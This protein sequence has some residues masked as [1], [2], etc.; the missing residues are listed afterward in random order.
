MCVKALISFIVFFSTIQIQAQT[1]FDFTVFSATSINAQQS[2]YQGLTGALG[3]IRL[4]QFLIDS[5]R[6]RATNRILMAGG[7]FIFFGGQVHPGE[8]LV[9]GT[10]YLS[11]VGIQGSLS[12]GS[13]IRL[14]YSSV[15]GNVKHVGLLELN[16]TEVVGQ[17]QRISQLNVEEHLN[18]VNNEMKQ[19]SAEYA[20]RPGRMPLMNHR[21]I[22]L[23]ANSGWNT[24]EI[25]DST[26]HQAPSLSIYGPPDA[27]IIINVKGERIR[28]ARMGIHLKGS[29]RPEQVLFNFPEAQSLIIQQSGD[30]SLRGWGIPG[31]FLAPYAHTHF[32]DA[33]ITGGLFVH[34]LTGRGPGMPAG[35]VNYSRFLGRNQSCN[36]QP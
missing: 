30:F 26:F 11:Q 1:L 33:L 29:L 15:I 27:I 32:H 4:G 36:C 18:R 6:D 16:R 35:Q 12:S 17:A 24:F 7:D 34:S 9:Q 2:D 14:N 20:S 22:E 28:I 8:I 25:Q 5:P 21:N 3:D 19:I 31:T 10:V 13:D 23:Y